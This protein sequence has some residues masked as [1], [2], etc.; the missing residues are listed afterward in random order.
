MGFEDKIARLM[1]DTGPARFFVPVGLILI[2]F[3]IILLGFN[4][5]NYLQTTGKVKE[6][7]ELPKSADEAQQYDVLLTYS[8]DGKEYGTTFSGLGKKYS[9]GDD[10]T[11][12]YDPA[13]P[14]KTTNSKLG[15]FIP[16]IVIAAGAAAIGFGI[17]KTL[18]AVKKS[19]ELDRTAGGEFPTEAFEG[20]K[21]AKCVTEYYFRFDGNHLK[22][23]YIVEDAGRN[24]LYEGKMT[25]QA[26]VG[27][28]SFQF[29][30]HA[31]GASE[32]HEV[33]HTVQQTYNDGF[34]TTKSWFKFDG[35]NIWDEV[36]DRGVRIST[37][38]LSKFPH[39]IYNIAR[40]GAPFAIAET[41]GIYVHEDDAAQHKLNVPGGSMY[42]RVWTSSDDLDTLFL[43][44]F[45]ISET[46][47][48]VVE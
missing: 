30:N 37:S 9:A 19:K 25:K 28:R 11:V 13:D 44:V 38:L 32:T 14:E 39:V 45:A 27:A 33:G 36:H 3:G 16:P 26:L 15:G 21:E 47:Q 17:Y 1:R 48:T 29:T 31:T 24:I 34:F 46:E 35:K 5:D 42:Y 22:P 43:T 20:F 7:I 8:V 23:G 41:T 2:I 40:N 6:V 10:I 18:S 12:Y 4:T